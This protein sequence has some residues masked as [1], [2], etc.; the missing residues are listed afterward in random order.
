MKRHGLFRSLFGVLVLLGLV[1]PLSPAPL[2]SSQAGLTAD[3][4]RPAPVS[5]LMANPGTSPGTV[6]LSWVAPGD[7]DTTGTASAYIVRYSTDPITESNWDAASDVA[8]EPSPSLAGRVERMTVAGLVP[9]QKI[10]FALKT[11]DEESNTSGVSNSALS[12]AQSW[13]NAVYLP[14]AM[15][16]FE[17]VR[18]IIPETTKVLTESTTQYL[19]SVSS[20]GVYT[21]TQS[22]PEL[23][24]LEP[25]DIMV[26]TPC[27]AAPDGFLRKIVTVTPS[28][29]QVIVETVATVLDEAIDSGSLQVGGELDPEM[30]ESST[31]APGVT[32]ARSSN[33]AGEEGFGYTLNEVLYDCDGGEV[34]V[35]GSIWLQPTYDFGLVIKGFKLQKVNFEMGVEEVADLDLNANCAWSIVNER[36]TIAEHHLGHIVL[37]MIGFVPIWISADMTVYVGADGN[38]HVGLTAGVRQE[39][40]LTAGVR[41]ANGT[42]APFR[43]FETPCYFHPPQLSAGLDVKIYGGA[44]FSFT[45]CGVVGPYAEV[46]PYLQLE[47]DPFADPWWQLYAGLKVS[48]GVTVQ[49]LSYQIADYQ[50]AAIDYRRVLAEA[51]A[52]KPPR[53]PSDPAPAHRATGQSRQVDLAWTGGDADGDT[54]TYDVYLEAN[55]TTP[56]LL[57]SPGQPATSYDPGM[58]A[59]STRY[60]WRIVAQDQHG[61][62]NTGPVW[63]FTTEI[64]P[65]PP[66]GMVFVPPGEFMMGCDQSNSNEG[67]ASDE[68][69]LHA[70]YLDAYYID[71]YE[72]TNAQYAQCVGTTACEPPL[73]DSSN[74]RYSYYGNPLYADYPV[75]YVSWYNATDYCTWAGKRLPTEAEWEK[76]ARGS[77]D[78][79]MYPWGNNA[80]NCSLLNY[81]QCINDTS[82]VGAYPGGASVYGVWD[83]S[84]NVFEW[85]NDWYD[86]GYYSY[87][88]YSNPQGPATGTNKVPRSS[89]WFHHSWREVRVNSRYYGDFASPGSRNYVLGFR[90]AATPAK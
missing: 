39:A 68:L 65:P 27:D 54:V 85:T 14:E 77:A 82:Q 60:Y 57:V 10:Y 17:D 5:N 64:G 56:D 45:L 30:I 52:N 80:P 71:T 11:Q 49:I 35:S 18:P 90:C 4:I 48:I 19:G 59:A 33:L 86:S 67:C 6:E 79:R 32:F 87:S 62:T 78:T 75:I 13:P 44:E 36:W 47:A 12:A 1:L 83:M 15:R 63:W 53:R 69:P 81:N 46:N 51:R 37:G 50:F 66:A 7:D 43:S 28:G 40:R 72:V 84:G 31:L 21:F 22:T 38:V 42:W 70:V 25:G 26:G 3:T 88:P 74:T 55:D 58:L 20:G 16:A 29:G 34:R 24:A 41:Y 23:E 89:N 2:A 61:A 73:F 76:A 8:D 9:R